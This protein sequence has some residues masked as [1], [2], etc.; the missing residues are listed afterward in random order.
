MLGSAR[1]ARWLLLALALARPEGAAQVPEYRLK[2]EFLERFTRF[3]EWPEKAVPPSAPFTIC[4]YGANPFEDALDDLAAHRKIKERDVKV[5]VVKSLPEADAC[6]VL[7]IPA[8]Q[9]ESLERILLAT[10][11]KPVLTVGDTEGFAER[12]VLVNFYLQES[13]VR[14]EVN[15]A[16]ARRAGLEISSRLLKL[17]RVVN[18][19]EPR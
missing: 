13:N 5:R 18:L 9:K 6:Q 17:A 19:A 11:G 7:F 12:G 10:V 15:D 8:A 16:A 1:P 3:I 4:L 14:F 2:A